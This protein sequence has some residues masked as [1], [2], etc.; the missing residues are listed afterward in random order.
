MKHLVVI[1][2]LVVLMDCTGGQY[3]YC[4]ECTDGE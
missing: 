3:P 4:V 1:L 2:T